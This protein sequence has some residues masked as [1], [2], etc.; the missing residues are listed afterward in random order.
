MEAWSKSSSGR[1]SGTPVKI[2][3]KLCRLFGISP[4]AANERNQQIEVNLPWKVYSIIFAG[5]FLL[6]SCYLLSQLYFLYGLI[7]RKAFHLYTFAALMIEA[8]SYS[9]ACLLHGHGVAR[10][11]TTLSTL[12]IPSSKNSKIK[13]ICLVQSSVTLGTVILAM[14]TTFYRHYFTE[15][16]NNLASQSLLVWSIAQALMSC[17]GQMQF[18]T[19]VLI[20]TARVKKLVIEIRQG[21][22]HLFKTYKQMLD[23][24]EILNT[25]FNFSLLIFVFRAFF[26]VIVGLHDIVTRPFIIPWNNPIVGMF[27][28]NVVLRMWTLI[29]VCDSAHAAV[30]NLLFTHGY[31][32]GLRVRHLRNLFSPW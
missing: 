9:F 19:F 16:A 4:Y 14:I 17:L 22:N 23:T 11:V 18:T 32:Y 26:N 7:P 3:S 25:A 5:I 28:C 15:V 27:V 2:L 12:N 8:L 1:I 21:S 10:A 30:S 6:L 20:L 31:I 29:Y 13:M 24:A